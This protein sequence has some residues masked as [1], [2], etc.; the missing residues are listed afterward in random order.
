MNFLKNV[1]TIFGTLLVLAI[2]FG[3]GFFV[4]RLPQTPGD[5]VFNS[6]MGLTLPGEVEKRVVTREEVETKLMEIG[7]LASYASEYDVTKEA[8]FKRYFLDDIAIPGT[9]N[10]I[11]IVCTGIVQ[12][13]FSIPDIVVKVDEV[14]RKIYLSLPRIQVLDNYIIWD[15]VKCSEANNILNPIDFSQ[16]QTLID[17]IEET[18][19]AKAEADGI[20]ASALENA[21][22]VISGFLGAFDDYEIIFME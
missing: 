17:E 14:S 9:T 21:K 1:R 12:V 5:P 8:E 19:L 15:S 2:M 18:G 3:A 11:T 7:E 16:Y 6:S 4:G 20:Y 10:R 13:G 22:H